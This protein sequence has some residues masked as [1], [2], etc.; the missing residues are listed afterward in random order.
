MKH[1]IFMLFLILNCL[2]WGESQVSI[3]VSQNLATIGDQIKLK[4]VVKSNSDIEKINLVSKQKNFEII[5]QESIRQE[6]QDGYTVIENDFT[7]AFFEV[8]TFDIG[9][10]KVELLQGER[11]VETKE[12]NSI[13]VTI[14][15]VLNEEDKDIKPLKDLIN[16]KG[17]PFYL[18]KYVFAFIILLLAAFLFFH[19]I[20]KRRRQTEV[21]KRPEL[22]PIEEFEERIR[23]LAHFRLFEKGKK[24]EYCIRLTEIIKYFLFREYHFNAE[25]FTT[26]ETMY[27]LKRKEEEAG[28]INHLEF[29][30]NIGDLAKFAKFDI[31]DSY[32][33]DIIKKL[34]DVI[35]TYN[36][37]RFQ[38]AGSP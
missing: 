8:G 24:I 31:N 26:Y 17:N 27:Y 1:R 9:P 10:F 21:I 35:I 38:P 32:Y 2:L 34:D 3:S 19:W 36:R 11:I 30:F 15:S 12:T 22:T 33:Q 4:V 25:D 7:I 6:K 13:P 16:M 14:K 23:E 29:L 37:R 20:N 5:T 18:L 28:I